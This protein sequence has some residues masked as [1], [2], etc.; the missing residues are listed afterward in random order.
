MRC[1]RASCPFRFS[2]TGLSRNSLRV[3]VWRLRILK[4]MPAKARKYRRNGRRR[5]LVFSGFRQC[6]L[7]FADNCHI[8]VYAIPSTLRPNDCGPF[9]VPFGA[10]CGPF[11]VSRPTNSSEHK[12][13]HSPDVQRFRGYSPVFAA[14]RGSL[15]R[16]GRRDSNSGP[17]RP[18]SLV[19]DGI[20]H[21]NSCKSVVY[22]AGCLR[23]SSR[24][25]VVDS[26]GLGSEM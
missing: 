12:R 7:T 19:C 3:H 5:F 14:V 11:A 10:R 16:S 26:G 17:H 9:A 8:G 1:P 6:S 4:G 24:E 25:I 13:T 22:C 18:E 21:E 2:R 20:R 23:L 15:S